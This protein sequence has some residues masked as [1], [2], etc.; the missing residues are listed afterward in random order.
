MQYWTPDIGKEP[1]VEM[2]MALFD[3]PHTISH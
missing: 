1:I 2:V 3:S